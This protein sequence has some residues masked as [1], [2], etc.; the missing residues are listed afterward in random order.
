VV[1]ARAAVKPSSA[2]VARGRLHRTP[3]R[4][5]LT[6]AVLAV[7]AL[8]LG[9][10]AA[11]AAT[12]RR[13]ATRSVSQGSEPQLMRAEGVYASLSA[14][15]ATAATTFLTGGIEPAGRRALYLRELDGAGSQL[16]AM[17]RHA[18][19]SPETRA[20]VATLA[21]QLP[22]YTGLVESARANNRQGF[23]VGAAYLR[24]ASL[25]MR[26]QL[27]PA[28]E[29]LYVVGARRMN[30]DYRDGTRNAGLI[31]T[32]VGA[33]L[34][35]VVLVLTQIGLAR[36]SNRVFNLPLLAATVLVAA[37]GLWVGFGLSGEQNALA[38][39]QR[40]GSDAVQLLTASRVL[41]LRAQRDD[42][43]A[44]I[45]RG[46]DTTSLPD[47]DRTMVALR[48]SRSG[49]GLLGDAQRVARRSGTAGSMAGVRAS[50]AGFERAHARVAAR[51][52]QGNY[53][54]AVRSYRHDEL[55]Q[56]KQ[57]DAALVSGTRAA[58]Q[59]FAASADD[60]TASVRGMGLGI[61][62]LAL[63]IAALAVLGLS[64][65]IREYR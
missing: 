3:V 61:P 48:G 43:L 37:L 60:A 59:R 64:Y 16:A 53:I 5:R 38:S 42:S 41:A 27:L 7:A 49:G 50:L 31:A 57:L 8:A 25:L 26:T 51:V 2:P 1:T 4:L 19:S 13:D 20:P 52:D 44:L 36:F 28:A 15:D 6:A 14:A 55:R 30:G 39:A 18:A 62:L 33:A 34:L 23:P 45:G 54:G 40:K 46:S 32:V 22:V 21:E 10:I 63:A 56:A 12:T 24:G 47:F 29:Q 17:A 65:R 11:T 35:F 9:V 58:Q